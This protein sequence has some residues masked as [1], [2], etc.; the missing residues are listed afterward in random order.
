MALVSQEPVLFA[1]SVKRNIC[2]GLEPDDGAAASPSQ[3]EVEAAARLA[4]AHGFI[5]EQFPDG[6]DTE[7]GEKGLSLSGGQKQR[8][9]I[10]RALVRRP[11][12]LLLDEATS[13]LDSD[14]EAVVQDALDRVMSG[15]TV[16]VVAH[17]LSTIQGADRIVVVQGGRVAEAGTHEELVAAGGAYAKLVARQLR[18]GPSTASLSG[19]G[20]GG[21]SGGG[22]SGVE[23]RSAAG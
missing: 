7:C 10:A 23:R 5:T 11:Q 12:L 18:G 22:G 14:S 6:Y 19:G 21:G 16:I 17:R 8:V 4:N 1:R 3:E 9:A 13:A 15:R 2:Y 20:G